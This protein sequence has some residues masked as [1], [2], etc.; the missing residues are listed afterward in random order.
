MSKH[1]N[2]CHIHLCEEC[3]GEHISDESKEHMIVSFKMRGS[4][5]KCCKHST[6]TCARY[7]KTCHTPICA[8]G[9]SF[10]KHKRHKTEHISK[11]LDGM[12]LRT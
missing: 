1:C 11:M 7:C 10:G 12:E 2:I 3:E 4:N 5:P 6:E 9:D 8:L